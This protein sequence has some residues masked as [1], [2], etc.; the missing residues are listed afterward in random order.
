MS[1]LLLLFFIVNTK[2]SD[3]PSI[4]L[5]N[6]AEPNLR[7]PV[8]GHGQCCGRNVTDWY[9]IA[10][11]SSLQWYSIGGRRW[12][13]AYNYATKWGV[14]GALL[15]ITQNWT[16]ISRSEI[17]ITSKI[18][19]TEYPN[20]TDAT[21]LG[22]NDTIEEWKK[23]TNLFNTTYIDLLL[24]HWPS[25]SQQ[26]IANISSDAFCNTDNNQ[27]NASL[28]RQSTWKALETIFNNKG[29]KAIGVSNFEQKHLQDIFALNSLKP[30]INQ[31]EFHGYWHEYDLVEFCQ[32]NKITV[33]SY[34]P[35]GA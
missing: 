29:A 5:Y 2:C 11:N 31:F 17:F 24:I 27:Y 22:Y 9:G 8:V 15:N 28:C 6:A 1:L 16:K 14:A 23:L 4:K 3:I 12:D 20:V 35:L 21:T 13:S 10:Y 30:A 33:N 32:N 18:G 25:P 19:G 7:M 26:Q 34:C